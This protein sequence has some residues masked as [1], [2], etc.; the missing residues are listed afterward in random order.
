[1]NERNKRKKERKKRRKEKKRKEKKKAERVIV[2]RIVSNNNMHIHTRILWNIHIRI[3]IDA[4]RVCIDTCIFIKYKY[5]NR[6]VL[7]GYNVI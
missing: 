7:L 6:H 4:S 2:K 1:M 5:I 3:N